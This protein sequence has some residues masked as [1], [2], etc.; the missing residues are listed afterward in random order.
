MEFLE[1]QLSVTQT[2][3]NAARQTI[4]R[5]SARCVFGTNKWLIESHFVPGQSNLYYFDGTTILKV[6]EIVGGN[7][8]Q[9]PDRVQLLLPK[10]L[11]VS[12]APSSH[13][14]S[15][16]AITPGEHPL[17]NFGAN[18]PWLAF[19]SSSYIRKQARIIP[20]PGAVI[21]YIP[22]AF[23]FEDNTET[24]NDIGLPR[25][26]EF[27]ASS[28]LHFKARSDNSLI[29]GRMLA[30]DDYPTLPNGFLR[31]QYSVLTHTNVDG[32]TIP[33]SFTYVQYEPDAAGRPA[34]R[35]FAKGLVTS[36]RFAMEPALTLSTTKRYSTTDFRFRDIR[37]IVDE[38]HY[39]ITNG[40]IQHISAPELQQ[41]FQDARSAAPADPAGQARFGKYAAL[42][43]FAA[44]TGLLVIG[45]LRVLKNQ[46]KT[47]HT[48]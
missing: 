45:F 18:L 13:E 2:N 28:Y 21:R 9:L 19:C 29:R 23:G 10:N 42:A 36:V 40:Q 5:W 8:N 17:D 37:K 38:I 31:G 6:T 3:F 43:T 46:N 16:L 15:F 24:F 20:L 14:W 1:V 27:L 44:S 34:L 30:P 41:L 32:W 7:T 33:T 26:V 35:L 39:S 11:R 12:A 25:K 48:Q 4:G 47:T 22:E